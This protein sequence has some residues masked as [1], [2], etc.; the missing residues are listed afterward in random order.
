MA[1][2]T[3]TAELWEYGGK[4]S[5]Y[6]VTLPKDVSADIKTIDGDNRRGFGSVR[7]R[8]IIQDVSWDTSVFP[9]SKSDAYVLPV[10]K[11]VRQRCG[12][13]AGDSVTVRIEL[14]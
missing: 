2:F 11:E 12:L 9:D 13:S 8:V 4:A 14:L 1:D 5:W 7:V 10:K 3:F 6:F